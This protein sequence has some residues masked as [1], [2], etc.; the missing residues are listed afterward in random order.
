MVA[1]HFKRLMQAAEAVK[2]DEAGNTIA[3]I[4]RY[5]AAVSALRKALVSHPDHPKADALQKYLE[6]YEAR[7]RF[8]SSREGEIPEG[9]ALAAAAPKQ[10]ICLE[11][12]V[13]PEQAGASL[14]EKGLKSVATALLRP[15]WLIAVLRRSLTAGG[16][17]SGRI[18]VSP[19]VWRQVRRCCRCCHPV[20][21]TP[22]I[23]PRADR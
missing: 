3:A 7:S 5:T 13:G 4:G 19:R 15:F 2:C 17:V 16:W 20:E 9:K 14:A 12:G 8:L 23:C 22:L 6:N 10:I 21:T 1:P 11:A 18:Y